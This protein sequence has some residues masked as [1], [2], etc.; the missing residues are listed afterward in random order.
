MFNDG[1]QTNLTMTVRA[2]YNTFVGVNTNSAFVHVS[3]ADGTRM[4][5]QITDNIIS[6]M[7]LPV[8]IENVPKS[9]VTGVNNWLKTNAV[10]GTLTGSVQSPAPGFRNAAMEDYTLA[11]NSL[12][13]GAANASVYGLPGK[14]YYLNEATN[15]QWRVRNAAHDLGAFEST[16]TNRP[17][18][19]YDAAPRPRL[20]I[21]PAGGSAVVSWP[22]FAQDFQLDYSDLSNPVTWSPA[23][24]GYVTNATSVAVTAPAGAGRHFFRLREI[25]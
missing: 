17:M 5:A 3:N 11:P 23:P 4:N 20:S 13:L 8:L 1:G 15:R 21:A 6:G 10:V 24:Y 19:P 16:S 25:A 7:T 9:S 18:G 14:E 12:C 2:I 22:L